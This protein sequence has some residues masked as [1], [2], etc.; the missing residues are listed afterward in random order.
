VTWALPLIA[1]ALLGYAAVSGRLDGTPLTGPMVFT[2]VGLLFGVDALGLVDPGI[3]SEPV[4]LLAEATLALVLFGDAS[5]IDLQALRDEV[6]IPARLLGFGLPLAILAGFGVGLVLLGA[7]SWPEA[8]LLAIILAP[9]D[10]ALGQAVVTLPTLPSR[11]RQ[12]LN[13]ESGLNDG[14]CVPALV[15]ALAL[16][17][18][19]AR[20]LSGSDAAQVIAEAIGYGLLMGAV[21]VDAALPLPAQDLRALLNGDV[22]RLR[23]G[24]HEAP[25]R[26]GDVAGRAVRAVEPHRDAAG[27]DRHARHARKCGHDRVS[28][29]VRPARPGVDRVCGARRRGEHP[30]VDHDRRGH[31]ADGD[32]GP[33]RAGP[34]LR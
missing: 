3:S 16:A 14:L 20:A 29:L 26:A 23:R 6:S 21:A 15:I 25:D 34:P 8:L 31:R 17:D 24:V 2:A 5:R 28:R 7:L 1:L 13:V 27:R 22:R 12:G 30:P 10:A 33:A 18:T 4:K 32:R 9:T 11:V 19:S